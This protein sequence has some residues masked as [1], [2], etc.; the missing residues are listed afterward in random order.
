M[1]LLVFFLDDLLTRLKGPLFAVGNGR[2][3][4]ERRLRQLFVTMRHARRT[5]ELARLAAFLRTLRENGYFLIL[6]TDCDPRIVYDM[7]TGFLQRFAIPYDLYLHGDDPAGFCRRVG[8]PYASLRDAGA[9]ELA[10]TLFDF[11]EGGCRAARFASYEE[12]AA[13]L[14]KKSSC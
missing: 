8:A 12:A 2:G 5:P 6:F 1:R 3:P 14:I 7:I 9:G 11:S 4:D 13:C 10:P